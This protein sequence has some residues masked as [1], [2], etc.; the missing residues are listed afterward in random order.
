MTFVTDSD[1]EMVKAIEGIMKTHLER[2][3]LQDFDYTRP[4]LKNESK[5][6]SKKSGKRTTRKVR[7]GNK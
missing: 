7:V 4:L 5:Q 3:K 2:R 1:T 6:V